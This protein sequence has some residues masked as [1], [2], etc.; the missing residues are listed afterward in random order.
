MLADQ[1]L[2]FHQDAAIWPPKVRTIHGGSN[3]L[4]PAPALTL[5]RRTQRQHV[6]ESSCSEYGPD[7]KERIVISFDYDHDRNY[8]YLLSALKQNP[9]SD[10]DFV[11]LTPS[12]IQTDSVSR[13][14]AVLTSK[15]RDATHILVIIGNHANSRHRKAAD[16]GEINWQWWE[17]KQAQAAGKKLIAVKIEGTIQVPIFSTASGEQRMQPSTYLP[18]G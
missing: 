15:I 9:R 16:I 6:C 10:I 11:D 8:R 3:A 18:T 7:G 1:C 13:I 4:W 17:I 14:K 12:E 2:A 5:S